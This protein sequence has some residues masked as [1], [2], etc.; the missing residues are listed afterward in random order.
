MNV[1]VRE[2]ETS[3]VNHTDAQAKSEKLIEAA[4][5][6]LFEWLDEEKGSSVTEMGVFAEL[7]KRWVLSVDISQGGA[8]LY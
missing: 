8:H 2:V 3:L 7:A 6:V 4:K 5:G 1:V